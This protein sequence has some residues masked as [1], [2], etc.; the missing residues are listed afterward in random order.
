MK[1]LDL[2]SGELVAEWPGPPGLWISS[3]DPDNE[4][5][6]LGSGD[7]R[8][9]RTGLWIY[10]LR[11]RTGVRIMP[12]PITSGQRSPMGG[13]MVFCL[14]QPL[15]EIWLFDMEDQ[16]TSLEQLTLEQHCNEM[17]A[18]YAKVLENDPDDATGTFLLEAFRDRLARI[19]SNAKYLNKTA[20]FRFGQ[21]ENLGPSINT[22]FN[23][24]TPFITRDGRFLYF[25]SDRPGGAGA[26][27][28]WVAQISSE[29][30]SWTSPV[31]LGPTDNG[32]GQDYFPCVSGDGLSLYFYSERE[33]GYGRGDIWV[34]KRR[35]S[36][37]EWPKPVNVGPPINGPYFDASPHISADG[38]EFFF[39][40]SRNGRP[41]LWVA[42]R[43]TVTDSWSD[44]RI[45]SSAINSLKIDS[46]PFLSADG[47]YLLFNSTRRGQQDLYW[48]WRATKADNW[49]NAV[50][51]GP[52]INSDCG[53]TCACLSPDFAY[54]YFCECM[55]SALRPGGLGGPDIW[56]VRI[57]KP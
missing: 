23:D 13:N 27:D 3:W 47:L 17:I 25:A 56:R 55:G 34:S 39:T 57:I 51:L 9:L 5:I 24:G 31:N 12:G 52:G 22:P 32:P 42:T 29:G 8:E 16:D 46:C 50:S 18:Y 43:A 2:L 26:H 6:W 33:G 48:T 21:V 28:I 35:F 44:P 1:I 7:A 20:L 14:G 30:G 38:L 37:D 4:C 36:G 19:T 15:Y 11:I 45:L 53:E 10:D 49:G 41:D 40:S 54:L